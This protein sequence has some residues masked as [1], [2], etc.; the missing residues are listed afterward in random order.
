MADAIKS[1]A[2]IVQAFEALAIGSIG[3]FCFS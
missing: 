2:K 3:A 1:R